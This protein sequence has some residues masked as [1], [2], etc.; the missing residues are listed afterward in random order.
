MSGFICLAFH[1]SAM[2]GDVRLKAGVQAEYVIQE[3]NDKDENKVI[4]ANNIIVRPY[5]AVSYKTRDLDLQVRG[6]HNQVRRELSNETV[7]QNYT[8]YDYNGNYKIINNVLDLQ[9]SGVRNYQSAG[10]NSFLVDDFLLNG[11]SLNKVESDRA[12]LNLN[13][14]RGDFFGLSSGVFYNNTTSDYGNS[15]AVDTDTLYTNETYGMN[16]GLVSGESL[17]GAVINLVGNA[18]YSK[19]SPGLDFASQ[20]ASLSSNIELYKNLGLA[21]NA[22]YDNNE[23][24]TEVDTPTN[25]LREFYSYGA[26][27]SWESGNSRSVRVLLNKSVKPSQLENEEDEKDT[28]LSYNID[29]A[30]SERTLLQANISKRFYGNSGNFLLSHSLKNW[31]SSIVYSEVVSSSSQLVSRQGVGLFICEDG[32]TSIAD[33]F[34]SDTLEPELELGQT[35]QPIVV[36]NFG[37]SDRV[38]IRKSVTA[39]TAVTRRRTTLFIFATKSEDEEVEINRIYDTT[40]FGL[41]LAFNISQKTSLE[42][43][44]NYSKVELGEAIEPQESTTKVLSLEFKHELTRRLNAAFGYRY[45]DRD[46]ELNRGGQSLRGVSGALTD[47]RITFRITYAF[48]SK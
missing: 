19:R 4:D 6:T 25:G 16:M 7:T 29:W 8:E 9:L 23:I 17:D 12:S 28:F 39:Q 34:L 35:L 10:L 5:G 47:N 11:E 3:I 37:L 24:K 27:F 46:G 32:S 26:G 20:F 18:N 45:L 21:L 40:T 2:A 15:R 30:F 14:R 1:G 22:T 31:R 13:V 36:Q 33:C 41:K 48:G 43:G 44:H 38:I 42:I